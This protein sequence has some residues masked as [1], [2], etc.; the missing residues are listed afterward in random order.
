MIF[1]VVRFGAGRC[2]VACPDF[3][4]SASAIPPPGPWQYKLIE[5]KD[6]VQHNLSI[7]ER[8]EA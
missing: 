4:S 8:G 7:P 1:A 2:P 3:K 6:L 5:S